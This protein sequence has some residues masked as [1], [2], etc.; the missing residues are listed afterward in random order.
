M[1]E[2]YYSKSAM[3]RD[4]KVEEALSAQDLR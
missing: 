3:T 2:S 1:K 4:E